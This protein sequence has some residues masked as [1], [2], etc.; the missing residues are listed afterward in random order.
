MDAT[1]VPETC[2]V[3]GFAW[4]TVA[5]A[6][7]PT[8]LRAA[9][10]GYLAVLASGDDSISVRPAP[11]VWSVMEYCGHVRDVMFNL[12]DRIVLGLAEDHPTP[13]PMYQDVR[14][15]NG[16]YADDTPTAM[17][18]ELTAGI[19]LLAK[20]VAALDDARLARTLVY[21]WPREADRSLAWVAAQAMHEAE[22]HLA[23]VQA[24]CVPEVGQ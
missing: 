18:L 6:D 14:I 23:D 2:D 15:E 13:K 8:R 19:G 12:R 16:L 21:G 17:A 11:D 22:H 4:D 1:E 9:L 3:C 20:A 7:I 24:Q 10:D 5:A